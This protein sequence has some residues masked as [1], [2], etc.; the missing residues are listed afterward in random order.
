MRKTKT[1][2]NDITY[3]LDLKVPESLHIDVHVFP[4]LSKARPTAVDV[5]GEAPM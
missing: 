2:H 5:D 4:S 1:N 3:P